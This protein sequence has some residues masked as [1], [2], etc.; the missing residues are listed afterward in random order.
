MAVAKTTDPLVLCEDLSLRYPGRPEAAISGVSFRLE[1]GRS[2]AVIG[3]AGS[4]KSTLL[5]ALAG[6]AR[7]RRPDSP[8][9]VGG[10]LTVLGRRLSRL[11]SRTR[12]RWQ[13]EVGYLEQD[14]EARL[15]PQLTVAETIAEP[16]YLR[17]QRFDRRTAGI[18][19]ATLLD[20]V[21]LPLG[22][23]GRYP[24]EL[25]RGQRQRVALARAL[26]LE[27]RLVVADDP[28]SG[29]DVAVRGALIDV[30]RQA[31][32]ER[33]FGAIVV[34]HEVGELRRLTDDLLVLQNG[35]VVG[36]GRFD[37]VLEQPQHPYVRRLADTMRP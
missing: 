20:L 15:H 7:Q 26:V 30:L 18:A 28:V 10:E 27:P 1:A 13:F 25:S 6:F 16:I 24:H 32:A 33:G 5:R 21:Q 4:G 2:L 23:M 19:V 31:Q 9:P 37:H 34:G 3:E 17:D 12:A 22:A 14:A 29:V 8:I 11:G 35:V 36:A